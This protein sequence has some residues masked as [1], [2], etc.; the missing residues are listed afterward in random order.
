MRLLVAESNLE[1][2][3]PGPAVSSQRPVSASR[4]EL[5]E[6]QRTAGNQAV[7]RWMTA[8]APGGAAGRARSPG[9]TACGASVQRTLV[10]AA[11]PVGQADIDA[12]LAAA[13]PPGGVA[14]AESAVT[15]RL[16]AA[17]ARYYLPDAAAPDYAA[18]S[19]RVLEQKK[20]LL[21]EHHGDGTWAARS[22]P[23]GY[24]E[25]MREGVRWF[26]PEEP[27]ERTAVDTAAPNAAVA[28]D[29]GRALEDI[30]A[31]ALTKAAIIQQLLGDY[32]TLSAAD[33]TLFNE[34]LT[35]FRVYALQYFQIADLWSSGPGLPTE[36]RGHHFGRAGG[37]VRKP[38]WRALDWPNIRAHPATK[39]VTDRQAADLRPAIS[40]FFLDIMA[41]ADTR[42][43]G[44]GLFGFGRTRQGPDPITN[45][46]ALTALGTST[47]PTSFATGFADSLR[48]GNVLRE[49]KMVRNVAAG[50]A[51][52]LVQLGDAH[53]DPVGARLPADVV[54]VKRGTDFVPLTTEA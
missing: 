49:A 26:T 51:P 7:A 54:R 6:L 16:Q 50:P 30:H 47:G 27:A 12:A 2:A 35:D 1:K 32:A 28:L 44:G 8:A 46:A 18:A 15:T 14:P 45:R 10:T 38:A 9:G 21:G 22:G 17:S 33:S 5:L 40:E 36:G 19:L 53:V 37:L 39:H 25:K 42:V 31:V 24:V 52:L 41:L 23:W 48:E 20:Y 34:T 4:A 43:L 3:R 11:G 29:Q 13:T